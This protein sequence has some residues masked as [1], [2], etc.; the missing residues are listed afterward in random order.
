MQDLKNYIRTL[1]YLKPYKWLVLVIIISSLLVAASFAGHSR[2]V[3]EFTADQ[4][5][6]GMVTVY[7]S[8][9]K[10]RCKI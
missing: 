6:E 8:L 2:A 4:M 1:G 7:E 9:L 10:D 3:A 5:V